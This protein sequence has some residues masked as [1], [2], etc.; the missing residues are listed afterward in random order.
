MNPKRNPPPNKIVNQEFKET[1]N[2]WKITY[3]NICNKT[4]QAVAPQNDSTLISL[5]SWSIYSSSG[6]I[7]AVK[8]Y[9]AYFIE[10]VLSVEIP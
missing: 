6:T 9:F 8:K 3:P 2:V 4:K 7:I 1:R 5:Y 10:I